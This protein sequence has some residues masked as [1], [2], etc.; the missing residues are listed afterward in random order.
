MVQT[1]ENLL[2]KD[3]IQTLLDFWFQDDENVNS[4]VVSKYGETVKPDMRTK[5]TNWNQ[6]NWPRD[7]VKR[8]V[9][10]VLGEDYETDCILFFEAGHGGL[11][12]HTDA[13][14]NDTAKSYRNVSIPLLVEGGEAKTV[15]FDN[16][17]LGP[18]A[19]FA[20]KEVGGIK[21]DFWSSEYDKMSNYKPESKFDEKVH[22]ELLDHIDIEN[23]HG[24]TLDQV[25]T[26][27]V[28]GAFVAD[29]QQVHSGGTGQKHKVG[30]TVFT[31]Q[32]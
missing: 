4:E 2:T 15:F 16:Y 19:N 26:W 17:W 31:H 9:D 29:S 1:F 27:N 23:L 28:G 13:N 14:V 25:V 24:L 32:K 30:I 6:D 10:Q 12:L 18:K 21:N 5:T 11:Q 3:E 7:I 8:V 22:A 20:Q